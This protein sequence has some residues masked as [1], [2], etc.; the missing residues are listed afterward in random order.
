MALHRRFRPVFKKYAPHGTARF[1]KPLQGP[2]SL[3]AKH[4]QKHKNRP[5]IGRFSHFNPGAEMHLFSLFSA[6]KSPEKWLYD[7]ICRKK[8]LFAGSFGSR[9]HSS[10]SFT[11]RQHLRLCVIGFE[12]RS[13]PFQQKNPASFTILYFVL[14]L[15]SKKQFAIIIC[16]PTPIY[17]YSI[18]TKYHSYSM[19]YQVGFFSQ[20]L[21]KGEIGRFTY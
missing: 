14:E 21:F 10:C 3:V 18:F 17:F 6:S 2:F 5:E 9:S 12:H 13:V 1:A 7:A 4:P 11:P 19:H 16:I 20:T 15:R 8:Q